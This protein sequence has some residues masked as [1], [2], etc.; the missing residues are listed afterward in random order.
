LV[1]VEEK[2]QPK[3]DDEA[4]FEEF[5]ERSGKR[6]ATPAKPTRGS[7]S[8]PASP[9]KQVGFQSTSSAYGSPLNSDTT[10]QRDDRP[11]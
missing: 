9:K 8:P 5:S 1:E 10:N 11:N 4:D 3:N 6:L 7:R 2:E